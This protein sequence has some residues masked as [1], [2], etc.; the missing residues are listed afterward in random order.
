MIKGHDS[1][2]HNINFAMPKNSNLLPDPGMDKHHSATFENQLVELD[3]VDSTNN[4]AMA[5]IHAGMASDGLVCLARHQ[6]AGKGQRGKVW[7]DE[8]GQNLIMSLVIEPRKLILSQLFLFSAS[9][10]LGIRD[11]VNSYTRGTWSIKWPNDILWNDRKAAGIL[12][13][14]VVQ[15]ENWLFAVVGVG[16]NLNQ[17]LFPENL[18]HAVSLKQISS[19]EYNPVQVAR[20]LVLLIRSRI[21]QLREDPESILREYNRVLYKVNLP[22]GL[23]RKQ[24]LIIA[25]LHGVDEGGLLL[26]SEGRFS[27]GEIEWVFEGL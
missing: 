16:M 8:P 5:R 25:T 15:G 9:V 24:E 10:S 3:S 23:R 26:T 4:Y 17:E 27:W 12:I 20:E 14:T 7:Q 2:N 1:N 21:S 18:P 13:E 19:S 22:V 6:W 11:L